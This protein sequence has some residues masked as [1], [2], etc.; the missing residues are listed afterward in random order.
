MV[1]IF[2]CIFTGIIAISSIYVVL[3]ATFIYDGRNCMQ[4]II[5]KRREEVGLS[6]D[7][8][9][10]NLWKRLFIKYGELKIK[11]EIMKLT[12]KYFPIIFWTV[13]FYLIYTAYKFSVWIN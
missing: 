10:V 3:F 7:F 12:I 2:I 4:K 8:K 9:P 6:T 11:K 5:D 13:I 1:D